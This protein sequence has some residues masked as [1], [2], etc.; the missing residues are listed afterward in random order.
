ALKPN[1]LLSNYMPLGVSATKK[2]VSVICYDSTHM[3]FTSTKEYADNF[4]FML[5]HSTVAALLDVFSKDAFEITIQDSVV[6]CKNKAIDVELAVPEKNETLPE[7][8]D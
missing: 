7:V 8:S 2:G 3:A 5:P 4:E 6:R 1:A